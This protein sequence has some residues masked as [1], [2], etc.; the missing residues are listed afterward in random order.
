MSRLRQEIRSRRE[1]GAIGQQV[2]RREDHS[3]AQLGRDAI[4]V[5]LLD[6]EAGKPLRRYMSACDRLRITSVAGEG[7][8]V[9]VDVGGKDLQLDIPLRRR[10]LLEEEHGDGIGLFARA[11]AGNPDPQRAAW[12][13]LAHEIGNDFLRQQ[14]KGLRVAEKAGDVD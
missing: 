7:D 9:L 1:N 8:R 13:L 12:R 14:I 4:A 3:F 5:V 10:D 11:A 6:E 2:L